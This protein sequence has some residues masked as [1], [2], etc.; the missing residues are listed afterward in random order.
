MLFRSPLSTATALEKER[1]EWIQKYQTVVALKKASDENAPKEEV[2]RL[3][4]RYA[5]LFGDR[6]VLDTG[7]VGD[8]K[9]FLANYTQM[10]SGPA[11]M[12][13]V[14][15]RDALSNLKKYQEEWK[16]FEPEFEKD[17]ATKKLYSSVVDYQEKSK[18]IHEKTRL[19]KEAESKYTAMKELQDEI[20]KQIGRASCRERV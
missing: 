6:T 16:K 1:F 8:N 3:K 12:D 18:D 14:R 4:K 5:T 20:K 11:I 9:R 19:R 10:T 15:Y 2:E 13:V 17:A 7:K